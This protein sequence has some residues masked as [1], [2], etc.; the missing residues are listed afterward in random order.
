M[1]SQQINGVDIH[2]TLEI[3][4]VFTEN[5]VYQIPKKHTAKATNQALAINKYKTTNT[6][7]VQDL[8]EPA[9]FDIYA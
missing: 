8:V 7:Y 5:R 9:S 6:K 1:A 3:K 4:H 2:V